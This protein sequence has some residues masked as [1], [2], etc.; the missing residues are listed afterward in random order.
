MHNKTMGLCMDAVQLLRNHHIHI[1]DLRLEM[2]EI[3][4]KAKQPLSFESFALN[5]NKTTFYRNMELFEKNNIV[6]KSE[7]QRKFFYELADMAKAHF[8][9]DVCHEIKDVEVPP[10]KGKV[11]S[12][13]IKGVCEECDTH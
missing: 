11:K 1:T 2:L 12:V 9:C 7:L 5:A 6:I 10:I 4:A 13:L 8:V 3:L